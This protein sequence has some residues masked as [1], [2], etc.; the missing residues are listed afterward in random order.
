MG[1]EINMLQHVQY[2]TESELNLTICVH[3][4]HNL[5]AGV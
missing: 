4:L 5:H 3:M 2:M 1:W